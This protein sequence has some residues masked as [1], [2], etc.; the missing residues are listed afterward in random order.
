MRRLLTLLT[1][2]LLSGGAAL[3]QAPNLDKV[4]SD[5]SSYREK[6]MKKA[7]KRVFVKDFAVYFQ[8]FAAA[9]DKS[10]GGGYRSTVV[11]KT[12][13]TMG[14]GLEGVD[15]E[16]LQEVTNRLYREYVERLE[17]D[18]FALVSADEAAAT[19]TLAE[20]TRYTGGVEPSV[21]QVG[22]YLAFTPAGT[23]F[24]YRK[25]T[26]SGK[27]KGSV[28]IDN[29]NKVS[30]DL[31]DAVVTS[32]SLVVPFVTLEAGTTIKLA[33]M[34]SKVKAEVDL[35]LASSATEQEIKSG[36]KASFQQPSSVATTSTYT[37]G[38]GAGATANAYVHHSLKKDVS[39]EGVVAQEKIVERTAAARES[40]AASTMTPASYA[41]FDADDRDSRASHVVDVDAATY[42]ERVF[43]TLDAFLDR[44]LDEFLAATR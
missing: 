31:G 10:S 32:V 7:P 26:A 15:V 44:S 17:A 21:A 33:S 39:I 38:K 34:G 43:A 1:V 3:A 25:A 12:K 37:S 42:A 18:G 5:Q 23:D 41:L 24:F 16:G 27:K 20:W 6:H 8:V 40:R 2:A 14:V 13:T 4:F 19:E 28:L 11:G 35:R 9:Q 29:G 30:R 36:L 22:G